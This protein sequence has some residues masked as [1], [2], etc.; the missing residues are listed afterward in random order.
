MNCINCKGEIKRGKYCIKNA[1]KNAYKRQHYYDNR[2]HYR[3]L[4]RAESKKN[5][6]RRAEKRRLYASNKYYT[7]IFG[8]LIVN[9]KSRAKLSKRPFS[10]DKFVIQNMYDNQNGCCALTGI[11]FLTEKSDIHS[12]RPFTPSIDRIDTNK[13]YTI[14]NIRLV[15]S[16]VNIALSDFGDEAFATMCNS[17][18]ANNKYL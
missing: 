12:R 4:K 9:A 18:V 3:V 6:H 11:K 17:F 13:G 16:I 1:C 7:D 2:E 10:I 8:A 5:Y 14:D 15:C